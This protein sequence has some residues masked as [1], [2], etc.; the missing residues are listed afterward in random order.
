MRALAVASSR[1]SGGTHIF[2]QAWHFFMTT[3]FLTTPPEGP[4]LSAAS[5][6][7]FAACRAATS[8]AFCAAATSAELSL[9]PTA[10]CKQKTKKCCHSMF[11]VL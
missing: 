10:H 8:A 5:C 4:P 2:L 11:A 1:I 3:P 7:F 9:A 6:A